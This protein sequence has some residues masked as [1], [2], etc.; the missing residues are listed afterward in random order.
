MKKVVKIT[1]TV[2]LALT[3]FSCKSKPEAEESPAQAPVIEDTDEGLAKHED[4]NQQ[5]NTDAVITVNTED[6][7][8]RLNDAR[9]AAVEAGAQEFA[10]QQLAQIDALFEDL[11]GKESFSEEETS[12]LEMRYNT[13][14]NYVKAKSAKQ[15]I[16]EN[17][18]ASYN[19][20]S[21]DKGLE[22]LTLVEDAYSAESATSAEILQA[23]NE[24][25]SN[26][27]SVL[28]TAYK[29]LAKAQRSEA[30]KAKKSADEVKAGVSRKE[31]YAEATQYFKDGDSLYSMQ[32]PEKALD[33]YTNAKN[34]YSELAA[35][36]REKRAAALAAIEEAKKRVEE[37]EQFA[38]EAD[39]KTPIEEPIEGIEEEDAVLLE[40]DNY[41]NPDDAV[42]EV[43][44]TIDGEESQE[45]Q[46]ES[47]EISEEVPATEDSTEAEE[48]EV[49]VQE[50]LEDS[51]TSESQEE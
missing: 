32:S 2:F 24:A 17:E 16:D 1:L 23:S 5:S 15:K 6:L 50:N 14:T 26:F 31:Q 30:L 20:S 48:T 28:I 25:Y 38:E 33:K 19:Q 21:Y 35:D 45:I 46:E 36:V 43:D 9:N 10:S 44:A 29:T 12:D 7:I 49:E 40:A 37:S 34:L 3:L 22:N 18:L 13:L 4:E 11:K 39:A 42:I 51:E 41:E 47:A 8:S 27:N